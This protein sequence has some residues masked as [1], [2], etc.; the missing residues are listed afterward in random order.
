V[1]PADKQKGIKSFFDVCSDSCLLHGLHLHLTLSETICPLCTKSSTFDFVK[2][3]SVKIR[4]YK[5][6][7]DETRFSILIHRLP[8]ADAQ[9]V[10]AWKMLTTEC[11]DD[12][13]VVSDIV[14]SNFT[15]HN[16]ANNKELKLTKN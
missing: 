14:G 4:N 12:L 11:M 13:H 3:C 15:S 1:C 9:V 16:V 2:Q 6:N 10:Q 7:A 5:S 8:T